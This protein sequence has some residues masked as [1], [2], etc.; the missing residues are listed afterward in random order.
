VGTRVLVVDHAVPTPDRDAGSACT[1]SYLQVL[2]GAGFDVTFLAPLAQPDDPY[3]QALTGLGVTVPRIDGHDAFREAVALLAP[4]SD[5]ALLHRAPVA[6]EV[7]DLI[8]DV[9]PST[10]VVFLPVDLHYL[11]MAR[12]EAVAGSDATASSRMRSIELGL[13]DAADATIVVSTYE[14]QLLLREVPG[15]R[16]HTVPILQETPSRSATNPHEPAFG[17]RRDLVFLGGYVHL[18]NVDAV[19][20]F[21]EEVLGLVREAGVDNRFVIAGHGV[22][23]SVAALAGED[24]VVVGHVPDLADLFATA[25][26]SVVPLRIGAGFKGKIVTSLSFGV[27]VVTTSI[28]AEGGGLVDGYDVLVA[29]DPAGLARHIVRLSRDDELWQDLS[30]ASYE[31]FRSR[32][33]HE[34]VGPRLVSIVTELAQR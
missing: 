7:I 26:M 30:R 23:P 8:H 19:H 15:A 11:R 22:P 27:P 13:V 24:V 1:Y 29:D 31:T 5:V 33:S 28:G 6:I 17:R 4:S 20:W 25:R 16:V 18:P 10:K 14:Q 34:A 12:E 2:A 3:A 32:F 21:V 9:S